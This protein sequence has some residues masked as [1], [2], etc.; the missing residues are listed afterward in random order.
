MEQELLDKPPKYCPE[1]HRKGIKAKVKKIKISSG[2]KILLCRTDEV[3][4]A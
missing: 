1:C 3:R 2:E 4:T